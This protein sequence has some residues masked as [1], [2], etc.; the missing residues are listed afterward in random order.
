MSGIRTW[1][2]RGSAG[3]NAYVPGEDEHENSSIAESEDVAVIELEPILDILALWVLMAQRPPYL[4]PTDY[5]EATEDL[6]ARYRP[7]NP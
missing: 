1:T 4:K 3:E 5:E 7:P 2:L 6:L